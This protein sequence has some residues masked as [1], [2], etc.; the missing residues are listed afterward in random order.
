M[1]FEV[2]QIIFGPKTKNFKHFPEENKSQLIKNYITN[3]KFVFSGL[4]FVFIQEKLYSHFVLNFY[5]ILIHKPFL[6]N[7]KNFFPP[8]FWELVR[9][10][11]P[12]ASLYE[13]VR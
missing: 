9:L 2:S 8:V 7:T 13:R 11:T 4:F 1:S 3:K 12:L 5:S 10:K 6:T